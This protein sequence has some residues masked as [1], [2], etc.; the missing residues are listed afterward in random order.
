M[1][2]ILTEMLTR[3]HMCT[4]IQNLGLTQLESTSKIIT[5]RIE[6]SSFGD[7]L[8]IGVFTSVAW[9]PPDFWNLGHSLL[10]RETGCEALSSIERE[11]KKYTRNHNKYWEHQKSTR[12]HQKSMILKTNQGTSLIIPGASRMTKDDISSYETSQNLISRSRNS[13]DF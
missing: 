9:G 3:A 10:Q 8:T 1:S 12:N 11:H 5:V 6:N 7:N 2:K 13:Q 4:R